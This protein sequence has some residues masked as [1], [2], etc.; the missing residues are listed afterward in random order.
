MRYIYAN[1][2]NDFDWFFKVDDDSYVVVENMRKLLNRYNSTDH[3][4]FGYKWEH[5]LWT[6]FHSGGAGYVLSRTTFK[7]LVDSLSN[8]NVCAEGW[9]EDVEVGRCLHNLGINPEVVKENGTNLFFPVHVTEYKMMGKVEEEKVNSN[10]ISM[11][12]LNPK[13]MRLIDFFIYR[14]RLEP[15]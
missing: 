14:F 7:L 12:Y 3:H 13:E 4:Y 2:L 9:A 6:G 1:Y 8:R 11:H 10:L 5:E 15:T